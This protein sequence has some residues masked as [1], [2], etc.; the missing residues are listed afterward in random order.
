MAASVQRKT[1][2]GAAS[3]GCIHGMP[4]TELG[5]LAATASCSVGISG[6]SLPAVRINSLQRPG[7]RVKG[8]STK[9]GSTQFTVIPSFPTQ[10]RSNRS[11]LCL[12]FVAVLV[13]PGCLTHLIVFRFG[14]AFFEKLRT[15]APSLGIF[16]FSQG[17]CCLPSG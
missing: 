14:D 17:V 12:W 5:P 7:F 10:L 2:A 1:T 13:C 9:P 8:V 3:S 15:L 6:A 11:A 4:M 16:I